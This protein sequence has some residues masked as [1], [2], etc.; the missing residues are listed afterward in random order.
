M[1]KKIGVWLDHSKAKLIEIMDG[2]AEITTVQSPY[3]R[4]VRIPGEDSS[5]IETRFGYNI[6]SNSEFKV[7]QKKQNEVTSYYKDLEKRLQK[8]D[9]ILLFGPTLAKSE[10]SNFLSENKKFASKKII[11]KNSDKMTENEMAAFV[12][13]HFEKN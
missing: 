6:F 2:G 7:H 11:Q 4:R 5:N 1:K 13:K 8:Y 3:R 10:L 9:M 12:R